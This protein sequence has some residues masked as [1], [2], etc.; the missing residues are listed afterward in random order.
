MD[1][2]PIAFKG[3]R[4]DKHLVIARHVAYYL[5]AE[6]T[7]QSYPGIAYQVNRDHTTVMYG[8]KKIRRLLAHGDRDLIQLINTV[9]HTLRANQ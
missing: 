1:I 6:Y 8:A 5:C 3:D 2:N 9:M 4:R 7:F